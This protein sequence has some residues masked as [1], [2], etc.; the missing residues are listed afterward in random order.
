MAAVAWNKLFKREFLER[1]GLRFEPRFRQGEDDAFWLMVLAHASRLAVI[2][3]R[4]YWYRRQREGAISLPWEEEGCPLPLVADRLLYATAYWKKCG[5]LES[6]LERGWVLHALWYYLLVHL[7]PAH[8]PLPRLNAE[9][10]AR[11]HGKFREWFSL[12]GGADRL[13]GLDKWEKSFCRLL[14]QPAERPGWLRR[15]W[16]KR[17]SLRRGRRGRYSALRLL[18]ASAGEKNHS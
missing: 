6:G 2:P 3:D 17:L 12:V 16:W 13:R 10:W 1:N 4:L 5:W 8:K 9:E 7:V 18:L 15:R 14:E 11:L